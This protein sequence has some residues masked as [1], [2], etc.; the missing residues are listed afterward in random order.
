MASVLC[1]TRISN[2]ANGTIA[3]AKPY[4]EK[5]MKTVYVEEIELNVEEMEAVIAPTL[6]H[7]HNETLV[8]D[9]N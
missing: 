3:V 5:A 1:A 4:E 8:S 2:P 9:A 7:N 6:G